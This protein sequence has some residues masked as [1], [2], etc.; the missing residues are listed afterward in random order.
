MTETPEPIGVLETLEEYVA[1]HLAADGYDGLWNDN[2]CGCSLRD[3]MPCGEPGTD[4]RPGYLQPTDAD[5]D[6]DWIG[7]EKTVTP[8][9]LESA[10]QL[11]IDGLSAEAEPE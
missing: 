3:F 2:E 8:T 11:R 6:I 4:C 9:E 10:G 5:H 7:P 1:R